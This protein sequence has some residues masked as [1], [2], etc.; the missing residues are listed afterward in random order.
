MKRKNPPRLDIEHARD[1]YYKI[2]NEGDLCYT[3]ENWDFKDFKDKKFNSLRKAFLKAKTDLDNYCEL[4]RV[5]EEEIETEEGHE[6]AKEECEDC[7]D[8]LNEDGICESCQ[9]QHESEEWDKDHK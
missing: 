4:E 8:A 6:A 9:F 5:E 1:L 2:Q 3:L 7:G